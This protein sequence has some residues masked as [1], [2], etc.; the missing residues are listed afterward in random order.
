MAEC[1]NLAGF[2]FAAGTGACLSAGLGAGGFL[3][4]RPIAEIVRMTRFIAHVIVCGAV[5]E[6]RIAVRSENG[7]WIRTDQLSEAVA[8]TVGDLATCKGVGGFCRLI[9]DG[10]VLGI[11]EIIAVFEDVTVA[12]DVAQRRGLT[13]SGYGACIVAIDHVAL[14]IGIVGKGDDAAGQGGGCGNVA[15]VVAVPNAEAGILGND[16]SSVTFGGDAA[17]VG[18]LDD[19][20]GLA[21]AKNA[22]CVIGCCNA[23]G[24]AA[25]FRAG[26]M[27][28]K[29]AG[30]A[31]DIGDA[32]DGTVVDAAGD[33]LQPGGGHAANNPADKLRTRNRSVVGAV[34]DCGFHNGLSGDAA[35][36]EGVAG[37]G[38]M[39]IAVL[40]C[41]DAGVADNPAD[42]AGQ[43]RVIDDGKGAADRA[44]GFAAGDGAAGV[45]GDAANVAILIAAGHDAAEGAVFNRTADIFTDDAADIVSAGYLAFN[46]EVFDRRRAGKLREKAHIV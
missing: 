19:L 29:S 6:N 26:H 37:D 43:Q 21:V 23:S 4:Y 45:S 20:T 33:D 3:R 1:G 38:R 14:V 15:G 46:G 42:R 35:N 8:Q 44:V 22:G 32:A 28:G 7:G 13:G 16:S 31:A 27:S 5:C 34:C 12:V 18:A 25:F 40:D 39:I 10:S 36:A 17:G 9:F 2:R 30:N 24:V 11:R 41:A